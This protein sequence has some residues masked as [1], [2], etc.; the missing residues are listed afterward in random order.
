MMRP[1]NRD[2]DRARRMFALSAKAYLDRR[3]LKRWLRLRRQLTR[4]QQRPLAAW[5]TSLI[6]PTLVAPPARE[7]AEK[8][9]A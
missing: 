1:L 2:Q 7:E 9:S 8:G 4:S 6:W 3:K 5:G